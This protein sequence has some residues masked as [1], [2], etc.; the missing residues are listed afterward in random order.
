MIAPEYI[1][2]YVISN[3]IAL[4]LLVTAFF[5]PGWVRW[6]AIIIFVAASV[7]NSWIAIRNPLDYQ[8]YAELVVFDV[9]RDF[10]EGWFRAHTRWLVLPIAACQLA[11]AVLLIVNTRMSR[12]LAVAGALVFLLAIS[13]FGVGSAF[14]FSITYGA[15]LVV[16]ARG[17]DKVADT[18]KKAVPE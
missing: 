17:L 8:G 1:V 3:T 5:R 10:I 11:I 4:V 2:P 9:Y 16:M 6:A 12:W 18:T 14:P 7:T 13:P 15:A